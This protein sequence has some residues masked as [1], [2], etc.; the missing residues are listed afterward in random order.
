MTPLVHSFDAPPS[1]PLDTL[2]ARIGGKALG[3]VEMT[4]LGLPVPAGFALTVDAGRALR[5]P[6][7]PFPEALRDAVREGLR[8]IEAKTGLTFA[9]PQAPLLVSVRSGAAASMPGMLDTV[10]NVGLDR[11]TL[12]GLAQRGGRRFALD[13]YR[14]LLQM[15]GDV[16]L[17]VP[18]EFF[19]QQLSLAKARLG[20]PAMTDAEL[21]EE[22]L[23]ALARA[24]EAELTKQRPD[25]FP[26]PLHAQLEL[27]IAAVYR[28]WDNT[29]AQRYRASQDISDDLGTACV[30]QAMVFGNRGPG[31]GAGVLFTRNPSTG[32]RM[33]YGEY[34]ENAQGED[35]VSGV[36]TPSS[37]TAASAV[38]GRE[39]G[40]LER[41]DPEA[42]AA[43]Q[44]LAEQLETHFRDVQDIEFTVEEGRVYLLQTRSAKRTPEAS[45][46]IA[47]AMAEEGRV[48]RDEALLMVDANSVETLLRTR[49]PTPDELLAQGVKPVAIGLGASPGV[50]VGRIVFDPDSAERMAAEGQ[51]VLLVRRD[52]TAEDIVAMKGARGIL[53]AAGGLTSHAA[54]LSRALG[55]CCVAG[56]S[57]LQVDYAAGTLTARPRRGSD[58]PP[59]V[60]Q[61]GDTLTVD[62][63]TGRVYE[64]ALDVVAATAIPELTTLLGWA[65]ERR[66]LGV[67]A[68]A[69]TP[70]D[71]R[72]AK[73]FGA[74][75]IGLCRTEHMFFADERLAA[76]RCVVLAT[77]ERERERWVGRIEA[78]QRGDFEEIFHAMAGHPVTIRLL[79]WPL[80]EFMPRD[81]ASLAAVA[82]GLSVPLREAR[83]RAGSR[84]EVNPMIGHRGVRVGLTIPAIYRAQIRAVLTAAVAVSR[85]GKGVAPELL[86]P[87]T[88]VGEEVR[89]VAEAVRAIADEVFEEQQL[90]V[91]FKVGTMIELPRACLV[92]GEMARHVQFFSF[93]TND[94][95]QTAFGISRDD[96]THFIP[97]YV[98][99]LGVLPQNP[100]RTLDMV[101]VGE[102]IRLAIERGRAQNP[103]LE[104]GVCGAQGGDARSIHFFVE[105]GV[106]YVSCTQSRLVVARLGAAQAALRLAAVAT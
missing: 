45:V 76:L 31:S 48:T 68:N 39:A 89:R 94:L 100:F 58:D 24:F 67:R 85:A 29:R 32:E 52:T 25:A 54:V 42:F 55:K 18:R 63:S 78:M 19:E 7:A 50:A 22:A 101:G 96:S 71:A 10:L 61:V 27:A 46:R 30:I 43:V 1:E 26:T 80:H 28:S 5:D 2:R 98:D 106:D 83:R 23:D 40:S 105:Q 99:E 81:D 82:S 8:G 6:E 44:R 87:L 20:K 3:L 73:A 102:L 91:A 64:G 88:A 36:R 38:P 17:G 4:R 66:T 33:L 84:A 57:T 9:D 14:R 47:V 34:L 62:G 13:A 49:L 11:S 37:L 104:L 53:T 97:A 77:D 70:R 51:D 86:I 74:E 72:T 59:R 90:S 16:V 79:D 69:D 60:F 15:F 92:A 56:A 12:D 41:K 21:D 93:G 35:V 65:D 95:T 103:N 75:G